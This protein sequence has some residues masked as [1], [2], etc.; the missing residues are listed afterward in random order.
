MN[1]LGP[2]LPPEVRKVLA[3]HWDRSGQP[4]ST[5]AD[6][7]APQAPVETAN[8][9]HSVLAASGP[10]SLPAVAETETP[11]NTPPLLADMQALPPLESPPGNDPAVQPAS[12][13]T[14]QVG[15][16]QDAGDHSDHA[17]G[18]AKNRRSAGER[19]IEKAID[20][21]NSHGKEQIGKAI[22]H[23]IDNQLPR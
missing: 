18:R 5:P 4:A 20:G 7:E 17:K 1:N 15:D 16:G 2:V 9:P 14:D 11:D 23:A 12:S 10:A 6:R 21:A 22:E 8:R 19:R 13:G 3:P